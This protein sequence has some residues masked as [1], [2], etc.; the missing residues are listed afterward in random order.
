MAETSMPAV[1]VVD[2]KQTV[3]N[4]VSGIQNKANGKAPAAPATPPEKGQ[5][6]PPADPSA[7]QAGKE[8]Y[9][10][11]GRE[12]WLTS[13][14]ARA[15]VQKGI[16]FEPRMDQLARLQQETLQLQRALISDPGKVI[17][18]LAKTNNI[19][20]ETLVQNVLRGT[21]SE[22]VKEAVGK[23]Y[24]EDVIE[25]LK[26]S[27]E[28]LRARE[29]AKYRETREEQDKRLAADGIRKENYAKFQ[30]VM[31]QIKT[32]IAEAMKESGL[33][34]NNSALG[35]EMAQM[36]ADTM[37][38]ANREQRTITPRQAIEYVKN[39]LRS[40]NTAYYETLDGKD[41]VDALGATVSDRIRKHFLKVAQEA[42]APIPP[43]GQ[44]SAPRNGERKSMD[45]DEF[46]EY[47]DERKNKG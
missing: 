24:Y 36:V 39:R 14:Q 6:Q 29:D 21:A 26:L 5:Q 16:A 10:V 40:V 46:H 8:K 37:R 33:P 23:W 28:Q 31:S 34:D 7:Q 19:P 45:M 18:N 3:A 13:E 11:E 1:S 22:S 20:L 32:N 17:A 47:L 27:P 42:G 2:P 44:R 43:K 15:Y 4:I 30:A 41:L 25:P 12:V 9:V 38:L 35:V